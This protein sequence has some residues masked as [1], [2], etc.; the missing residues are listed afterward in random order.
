MN[1]REFMDQL[2]KR[3]SKL[4]F[5]EVREAVDYYEQYFDEAGEENEQAVLAELGS[6]AGVASQII[7]D[8]AVKDA[9]TEKTAKRGF[10][11]M[12]TVILAVFASPIALPIAFIIVFT[13]LMLVFSLIMF[14]FAIGATGV[15]AVLGGIMYLVAGI[16]LLVKDFP[17]AVLMLGFALIMAGIGAALIIAT[18]AVSKKCFGWLARL[19]GR[20]IL[21]RNGK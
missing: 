12:W 1:R 18:A 4:P 3:L 19:V 13:A 20:F 21:R 17:A 15:G 5:D 9:V 14:I 2:K 8:F 16:L 10:S 7:A 11:T 6:P